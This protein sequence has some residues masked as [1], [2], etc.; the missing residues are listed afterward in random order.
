MKVLIE[1]IKQK[2]MII[3]NRK[4]KE[5]ILSFKINTK[6]YKSQTNDLLQNLLRIIKS[7]KE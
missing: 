4:I 1:L 2:I 6:H 5:G 3:H 7:Y